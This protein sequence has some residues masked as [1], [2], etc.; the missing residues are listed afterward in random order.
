MKDEHGEWACL[1]IDASSEGLRQ[2][3]PTVSVGIENV[4][5]TTNDPILKVEDLIG[6]I[7]TGSTHSLIKKSLLTS[8]FNGFP[9]WQT[10]S[11]DSLMGLGGISKNVPLFR[12][13]FFYKTF[14]HIASFEHDFAVPENFNGKHDII[15][16]CD[17]LLH[18]RIKIDFTTGR[19][20]LQFK[21]G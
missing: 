1:T 3:G 21:I 10:G 15:I 9:L 17:L 8:R 13:K 20:V 6:L 11:Q 18:N 14:E 4:G 5:Q 7:D 16:G 2:N 12:F 19:L